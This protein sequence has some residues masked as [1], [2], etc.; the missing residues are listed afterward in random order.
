MRFL[1]GTRDPL[2][3]LKLLR[4][5]CR[6]LGGRAELQVIEGGDHSFRVPRRMGIPDEEIHKR[7]AARV[8]DWAERLA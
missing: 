1:Q 3:D 2:A 7:L 4:P 8:R 5:V 6:R